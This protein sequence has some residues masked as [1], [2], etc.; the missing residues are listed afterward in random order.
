MG[1]RHGNRGRPINNEVS[2][3][4][5]T[6]AITVGYARIEGVLTRIVQSSA[7]S[8]WLCTTPARLT[9]DSM[10]EAHSAGQ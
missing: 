2:R 4:A 8:V 3:Q 1:I 5:T 10:R 9:L 6:R 7:F